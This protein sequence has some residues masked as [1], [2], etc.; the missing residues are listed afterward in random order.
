MPLLS[1]SGRYSVNRGVRAEYHMIGDGATP[2]T[3]WSTVPVQPTPPSNFYILH[4]Q[5]ALPQLFKFCL[6]VSGTSIKLLSTSLILQPI[7]EMLCSFRQT[8]SSKV[9]SQ[10]LLIVFQCLDA[11]RWT[12]KLFASFRS[13][14]IAYSGSSHSSASPGTVAVLP[15]AQDLSKNR[16]LN[17]RRL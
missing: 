12:R 10:N 8:F 16:L 6:W 15:A 3:V 17:V 1:G 5:R 9:S 2:A 4:R 11:K 14:G 13:F 7:R